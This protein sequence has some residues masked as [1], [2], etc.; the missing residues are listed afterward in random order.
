M[1]YK[2]RMLIRLIGVR[3]SNLVRGNYQISLFDNPF[4]EI[5]LCLAM[6][7][8]RKKFGENKLGRAL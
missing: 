8:L 4:K 3:F 2:R 7:R 1:Y 5:N 6:D